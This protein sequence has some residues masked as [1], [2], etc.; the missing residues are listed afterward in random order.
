MSLTRRQSEVLAFIRKRLKE[1]EV[2]PNYEE[3]SKAMGMS[4]KS[5]VHRIVY[6][7]KERG[8]I[9]F[10]PKRARSIRVLEKREG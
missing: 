5:G 9:D 4:S 1:D 3:I 6:A 2:G 8:F 7:L 10:I